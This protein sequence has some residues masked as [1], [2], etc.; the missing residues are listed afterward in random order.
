MFVLFSLS[1]FCLLNGITAVFT[2]III[3]ISGGR[4][5]YCNLFLTVINEFPQTGMS[6]IL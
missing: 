1:A 4:V 6:C 3:I 5:Y 2:I